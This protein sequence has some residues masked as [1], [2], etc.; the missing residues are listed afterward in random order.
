MYCLR[1][2]HTAQ[3]RQRMQERGLLMNVR[4]CYEMMRGDYEDVRR[5]FLT[6][7]RIRRFALLFLDDR[8]MED[9]RGAM[10]RKDCEG[11]FH[12]AHTMKGVCL[13]LGLAGL[14]RPV[15]QITELLRG[16]RFTEAEQAMQEV[17]EEY[18]RTYESLRA[19]QES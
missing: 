14:Y 8:S 2:K 4:E 1:R 16:S 5:R 17:E 6:D 13:N 11:A 18:V 3:D 9:L 7:A 12:A 15:E 19:L 10:E